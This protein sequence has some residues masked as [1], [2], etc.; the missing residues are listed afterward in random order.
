ML[1]VLDVQCRDYSSHIRQVDRKYITFEYDGHYHAPFTFA[2]NGRPYLKQ[3]E[4]KS[5]I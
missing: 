4:T 3:Y 5:G 2:T 1:S